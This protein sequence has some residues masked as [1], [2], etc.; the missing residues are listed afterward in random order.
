MIV[1]EIP[2]VQIANDTTGELTQVTI[3]LRQHPE[4]IPLLKE[5]GLLPKT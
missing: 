1:T 5:I 2:G 4:A 3:D